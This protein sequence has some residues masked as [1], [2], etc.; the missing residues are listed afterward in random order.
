MFIGRERELRSLERLYKKGTFQLPVIYGRRRVGKTAIIEQFTHDLPTV[1]FTAVEADGRV[2][3][4]NL[5]RE[6][7]AFEHPDSNS[8][9]APLYSDFYAAFEAVFDLAL[10][11]QL[12]FVI[13]EFP[14]LAKADPGVPS[15]LQALV[16]RNKDASHLFLILCGSSLSFMKEQVFDE[17]SPLYGRRTAQLEVRPFDFFESLPF[18]RGMGLQEAA[19]AYGMVGGIPLYLLQFD[20]GETLRGNVEAAFLDPSSILYE[21]PVN[22]LKQEIQKAS[23]YN[24]MLAAIAGGASQNNQIATAVGLTST[25]I[26]YYLKELQRLELVRREVPIL[27]GGRRAVYRI[28]DNLFRFWYRFV[29]PHRPTIERGITTRA[30][31]AV[32]GHMSEYMGPVFEEICAQWIWRRYTQGDLD[33][34]FD[35]IGRWWGND[36]RT[37][38]EAEIDI[39]CRDAATATAVGECKWRSEAFPATDLE[40]LM[41]RSPLV[42]ARPDV[43]YYAFSKVGFTDAS[44]AYAAANDA[45]RLVSLADMVEGAT[46]CH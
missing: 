7:Y 18:L 44:K 26:T 43:R 45:V 25:E 12:V 13:D 15:Y 42:S 20:G 29:M 17:K 9:A 24:A 19:E 35:D 41:G 22:L 46:D 40:K 5:S 3:L 27:G 21:E 14:Y 30:L 34:D 32:E 37:R 6:L 38:Q 11:R 23:Q 39:V 16:D 33:F 1:Y 4:R 28:S 8:E 10:R 2:N 31:A 36:P